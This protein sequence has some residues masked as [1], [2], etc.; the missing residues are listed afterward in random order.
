MKLDF[1][2]MKLRLST[3]NTNN[4]TWDMNFDYG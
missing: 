2:N 4:I 1:S 3:I